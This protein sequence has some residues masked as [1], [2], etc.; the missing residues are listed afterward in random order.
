MV[1]R[2][3]KALEDASKGTVSTMS[4]VNFEKNCME[5]RRNVM[6][7]S[8][9]QVA[10]WTELAEPCPDLSRLHLLSYDTNAAIRAAEAN[11][12]EI[13]SL[14]PGALVQMRLCASFHFHVTG[15]IDK[16]SVLRA[17]ADRL[18]DARS[19]EHRLESGSHADI[20]AESQLDIWGDSSAIVYMSSQTRELGVIQSLNTA[21]CKLFGQTR[22]QLERR[23]AFSLLPPLLDR[24]LEASLRQYATSGEAR[25]GMVVSFALS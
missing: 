24:V 2:T 9:R 18:E 1:Y 7:A 19:R 13:F 23:S 4:R 10:F 25:L 21:A 6:R 11:F 3:R 16:A 8:S 14:S 5:V 22:V 12:A 15:N 17:E 20:L